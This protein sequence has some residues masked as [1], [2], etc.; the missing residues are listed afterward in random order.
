MPCVVS[1]AQHVP[2][3]CSLLCLFFLF[4]TF[5]VTAF[6][7]VSACSA[8]SVWVHFVASFLCHLLSFLNLHY[9]F[10]IFPSFSHPLFVIFVS[11]S[12]LC[13]FRVISCKFRTKM[14]QNT[15]ITHD[16]KRK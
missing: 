8:C 15:K 11:F 9:F 10:I 4:S 6:C 1:F 16:F 13:T 2:C 3:E 12:C 5:R 14:T 7:A